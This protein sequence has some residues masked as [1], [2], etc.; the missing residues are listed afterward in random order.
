MNLTRSVTAQ[1]AFFA[2]DGVADSSSDEVTLNDVLRVID[3]FTP[4]GGASLELTAW[5][6]CVE[7]HEAEAPWRQA[8]KQGLLE[9]AG[10]DKGDCM[11]RLSVF[12]RAALERC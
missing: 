2:A 4:H 8:L 3:E 5:E 10:F 11:W 12:G 6:L 7:L 1:V 9:V